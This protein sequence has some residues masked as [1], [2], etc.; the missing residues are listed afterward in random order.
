MPDHDESSTI[1]C[2]ACG[3]EFSA[4]TSCPACGV[5]VADASTSIADATDSVAEP[6]PYAAPAAHLP[7]AVPRLDKSK[8]DFWLFIVI[9]LVVLV[10]ALFLSGILGPL[11]LV[12]VLLTA[13]AVR[14]YKLLEQ[15]RDAASPTTSFP[16]LLAAVFGSIGAI[17]LAI[18]GGFVAFFATCSAVFF[19]SGL[20][21]TGYP[22]TDQLI[23]S[24]VVI[25]ASAVAIWV[26]WLRWPKR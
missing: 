8:T 24:G 20:D 15:Q 1:R 3:N 14:T 7:A 23:W 12:A 11:P 5:A 18:G 13:T 2:H 4:A 10:P 22:L 17:T 6:N 9:G 16:Q 25:V 19:A 21:G 26:F